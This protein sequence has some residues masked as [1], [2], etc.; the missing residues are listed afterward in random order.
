MSSSNLKKIV[1]TTEHKEALARL[2]DALS[3]YGNA[4][5]ESDYTASSYKT[6]KDAKTNAES[7]KTNNASKTAK[8]LDDAAQKL[9]TAYEG[10]QLAIETLKD[11]LNELI[12]EC[13]SYKDAE[14]DYM[15]NTYNAFDAA[16]IVSPGPVIS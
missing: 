15:P 10:L 3:K 2:N 6:Y 13:I 7:A 11:E 4:G 14:E 16:F 1:D 12:V 5:P 9:Q 8:E